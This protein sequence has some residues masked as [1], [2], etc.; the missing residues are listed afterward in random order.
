VVVV[1]ILLCKIRQI[2]VSLIHEVIL[3]CYLGGNGVGK[4]EPALIR[5]PYAS[6]G[7]P[8]AQGGTQTNPTADVD[9]QSVGAVYSLAYQK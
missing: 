8:I 5:F 3:S 9:I 6:N 1:L 4:S 7:N 2:F